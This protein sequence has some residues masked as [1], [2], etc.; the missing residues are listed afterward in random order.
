MGLQT[1]NDEIGNFINRKYSSHQFK[2]AVQILNK[3]NIDIVAHIMVG[4][5]NETF[6][7]II[8]T[9]NFINVL[10]IQG[11]KIHSTYVVKNTLLADLYYKELYE[12]ISLEYYLKCLV[13]IITHINPNF[14]I[15]RVSG[16]APKDILVAPDWNIHKKWVLNGLDKILNEDDLWQGM[17]LNKNIKD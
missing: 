7:D 17:Y 14:V 4:L 16:D 3:Y 11:V 12:P 15:H 6:S 5:P 2:Q 1:S 8:D 9:V 13:Y 10:P